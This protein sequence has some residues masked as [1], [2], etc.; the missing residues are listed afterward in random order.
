MSSGVSG[1]NALAR[2]SIANSRAVSWQVDIPGLANLVARVGAEGL[3]QL[4]LVGVDIHTIGCML[5]LG[6]LTP[7]S[8]E[9]RTKVQRQRREQKSQSWCLHA[10]VE[11]GAAINFVVD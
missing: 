4:A 1:N 11:Y 3:K 10:I 9:F 2:S 7:A 6:E 5:A 8:V